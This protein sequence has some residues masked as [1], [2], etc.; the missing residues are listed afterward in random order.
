M[1]ESPNPNFAGT[2]IA[3]DVAQAMIDAYLDTVPDETIVTYYVDANQ[4]RKLLDTGAP[5][6]QFIVA[7]NAD[8]SSTT[9]VTVGTDG[10]TNHV[11]Y[12]NE[13]L[14]HILPADKT[15]IPGKAGTT[16]E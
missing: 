3:K 8:G 14:E 6:I 10:A 16:L 11:Y 1:S 7:Q 15:G 2:F 9:L 13:V 12:D 4:L 5:E